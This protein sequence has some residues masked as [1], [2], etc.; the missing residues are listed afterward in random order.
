MSL[1]V[2]P[3]VVAAGVKKVFAPWSKVTAL[4]RVAAAWSSLE[5]YFA[6]NRSIERVFRHSRGKLKNSPAH[7]IMA[8]LVAGLNPPDFKATVTTVLA[9]KGCWKEHPGLVYSVA[10]EA[11]EAWVTVEQ[12][13]KLRRV[14]SRP[15][16]AVA[17]VGSAKEEEGAVVGRGGQESSAR[18]GDSKPRGSCWNC[19]KE[20]HRM[21]ECTTK[22]RSGPPGGQQ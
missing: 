11:A 12:A 1:Q 4:D 14:Q 5:E 22:R 2:D 20:C 8:K 17:R 3:S 7:I 18:S 21:T 10:R 15:K 19:G 9:L 13:D 16:G 6:L